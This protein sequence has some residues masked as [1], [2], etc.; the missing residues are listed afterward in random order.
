VCSAPGY[1]QIS[2]TSYVARSDQDDF[3]GE[4][5]GRYK[6]DRSIS[7]RGVKNQT[8]LIESRASSA[9]RPLHR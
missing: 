5:G 9:Q 6:I 3:V 8:L 2:N 7:P 4:M 1:V